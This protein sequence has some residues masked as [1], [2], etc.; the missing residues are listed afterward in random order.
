MRLSMI[1]AALVAALV[2]YGSSIAILLLNIIRQTAVL[3]QC[4]RMNANGV[5]D[6]EFQPRQ[7]NTVIWK[8]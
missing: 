7:A 3:K 2:G 4:T 5:V 8:G 1:S 6:N